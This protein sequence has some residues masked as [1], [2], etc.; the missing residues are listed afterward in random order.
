MAYQARVFYV[1]PIVVAFICLSGCFFKKNEQSPVHFDLSQALKFENV[2]PVAIIGSGPAGLSAALYIARA[3]MKA[4]VFGGPTPCGQLTQTTYIENWPG[5]EKVL[6]IDLMNDVK[7]QAEFFGACIINDTVTFADFS[8][9][10][11]V[12]KTE[13][14]REFKALSVILATGAHPKQLS[15]PGEKKYWGKGVTTCAVCDA[16]F[17]VGKHVIIVGG[18]DSAAEQVFELAPYVKKVT[19]LVRG[20]SM[21]AAKL[22][23]Q[24]VLAYDNVEIEYNKYLE[25]IYGDDAGVKFVDVVDNKTGEVE[26]R[27]IDGV[28]L[29][30]GHT[31]NTELFKKDLE[32]DNEGYLVMEGRSQQAALRPGVFAA[33]EI[34]DKVYRQAA[35]ASGEG[36]KAALDATSFLYELGFNSKVGQTLENNFFESFSDE[37]IE[38]QEINFLAEFNKHV[39]EDEGLVV[40]DF[41]SKTCPG[42]IRMLPALESLS[43]H[44]KD[45]VS[46]LKCNVTNSIEILRELKFNRGLQVK[47]VPAIFIFKNGKFLARTNSVMSRK[48][49]YAFVHQYIQD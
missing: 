6:G 25:G 13:E 21:R 15:I 16:P 2:V 32:L 10:P 27:P 44:L 39:I 3:G 40:I 38:L 23:Q 1:L 48:E 46:I 33:G 8:S 9:W 22:M 11:F 18:G 35:V 45:K 43:F 41:Y 19:L 20:A 26:K 36:I 31:P 5:R 24:R 34:Q 14:G 37:R 12:I 28:F 30:I 17:F 29:A 49:L 4:F 42:C 7:H 47:S